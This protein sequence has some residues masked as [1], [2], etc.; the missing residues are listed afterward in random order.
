[1]LTVVEDFCD[2][3]VDVGVLVDD[4][5]VPDQAAQQASQFVRAVDF[6]AGPFGEPIVANWVISAPRET[7]QQH[8][9]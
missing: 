8:R 9:R 4:A 1:M 7:N 6:K 3:H 5:T 2:Q